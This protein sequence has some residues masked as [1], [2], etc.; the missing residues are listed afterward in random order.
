MIP[1]FQFILKGET[2]DGPDNWRDLRVKMSFEKDA[3]IAD[4]DIDSFIFSNR[5]NQIL[6]EHKD[7]NLMTEGAGFEMIFQDQFGGAPIS[8]TGYV[9]MLD[10]FQI[11][12]PVKCKAKIIFHGTANHIATRLGGLT[13]ELLRQRGKITS[14]HYVDVKYLVEPEFTKGEMATLELSIVLMGIQLIQ[15]AKEISIQLGN[16][17]ALVANI[18]TAPAAAIIAVLMLLANIVYFRALLLLLADLATQLKDAI[19]PISETAKAIS[20]RTAMTIAFAAIGYTFS[21]PIYQM[22]NVYLPSKSEDPT[23]QSYGIPNPGDNGYSCGEML[24]ICEK[25]FNAK[26]KVNESAKTI[27]LL[28]ESDAGWQGQSAYQMPDML[29]ET[30]EYNAEDLVGTRIVSYLTDTADINTRTNYRG[31]A[32]EVTTTAIS[33]G[34]QDN[35]AIKG[36]EEIRIPLALGTRKTQLSEIEQKLKDFFTVIDHAMVKHGAGYVQLYAFLNNTVPTTGT[37]NVNQQV[38]DALLKGQLKTLIEDRTAMLKVSSKYWN[39]PKDIFW[40]NGSIPAFYRDSLS[41]KALYDNFYVYK[42]LVANDF[43]GQKAVYRNQLI[44]FTH[45]NFLQVAGN[46]YF[47]LPDGTKGEFFGELEWTFGDDTAQASFKIPEKWCGNLQET[48]TEAA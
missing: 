43:A 45:A 36:L 33:V 27:Q 46:K 16:V 44:P 20:Y 39:V 8:K 35:I 30:K 10:G 42:S 13:F 48:K 15:L 37:G 40:L 17:T 18:I 21:S 4:I 32:Y 34:V 41:A 9:N 23:A 12:S 6:I 24:E 38:R 28:T 2:V 7:L 19:Y 25:K 31:T 1:P 29:R 47:T 14:S 5:A 11:I 3:A 26:L 22:D